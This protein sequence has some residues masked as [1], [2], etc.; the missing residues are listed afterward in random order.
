MNNRISGSPNL[1]TLR[2]VRVIFRAV[3]V[4]LDRLEAR[5]DHQL[6]LLR[7]TNPSM[8]WIATIISYLILLP[9]GVLAFVV[10]PVFL[11]ILLALLLLVPIEWLIRIVFMNW[12]VKTLVAVSLVAGLLV[13]YAWHSHGPWI[14]GKWILRLCCGASFAVVLLG[15]SAFLL[16][17]FDLGNRKFA[18]TVLAIIILG[19]AVTGFWYGI[20]LF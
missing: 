20:T 15:I 16:K 10:L 5:L 1:W 8:G 11:A 14:L 13:G 4:G 9:L 19:V 17:Y 18:E 7:Q 2:C 12:S 6:K 3:T